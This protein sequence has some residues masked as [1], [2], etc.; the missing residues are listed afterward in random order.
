MTSEFTSE[1]LDIFFE[2]SIKIVKEDADVAETKSQFLSIPPFPISSVK[3]DVK[4]HSICVFAF[5]KIY[6]NLCFFP[7]DDVIKHLRNFGYN[8]EHLCWFEDINCLVKEIKRI[9]SSGKL[10]IHDPTVFVNI[11]MYVQWMAGYTI[12]HESGCDLKYSGRGKTSIENFKIKYFRN[13]Y[14]NPIDRRLIERF[15]STLPGSDETL[16]DFAK[17]LFRGQLEKRLLPDIFD[18]FKKVDA[19]LSERKY[20]LELYP[21]FRLILRDE[22]LPE[23]DD[24]WEERRYELGYDN[25]NEFKI[26]RVKSIWEKRINKWRN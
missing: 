17:D 25:F 15:D 24:E 26:G 1:I 19:N 9:H 2:E 16:F 7:D 20:L 18:G 22:R 21:L 10:V 13:K 8:D 23:T 5:A 3:H 4:F 12:I 11:V 6:Q 14:R